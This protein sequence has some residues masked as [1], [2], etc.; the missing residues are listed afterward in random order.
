MST[1]FNRLLEI[2]STETREATEDDKSIAFDIGAVVLDF[3]KKFEG[4]CIED[5]SDIFELCERIDEV[6]LRVAPNLRATVMRIRNKIKAALI[7][8]VFKE[9]Y[10]KCGF[11]MKASAETT[12]KLNVAEIASRIIPKLAV[13]ECDEFDQ[14]MIHYH[15]ED[16]YYALYRLLI[17]QDTNIVDWDQFQE[18]LPPVLRNKF[19]PKPIV[20]GDYALS[21]ADIEPYE[22]IARKLGP[23]AVAELLIASG[24]IRKRNFKK[25][26]N[27]ISK[28]LG[29]CKKREPMDPDDLGKKG[30]IPE[31]LLHKKGVYKTI[32][33][34][35]RNYIYTQLLG[36][37]TDI[38]TSVARIRLE[39]EKNSIER[40][41]SEILDDEDF[42]IHAKLLKE[43]IEYFDDVMAIKVPSNM[44]DKLPNNN[45]GED[46]EFPSLRQ[47]IAMKEMKKKRRQLI[48]FFMG[49]GK[50]AA[51]FLS[52]EYV[53][54]KR[55][56]YI[57]PPGELEKEIAQRVKKYYKPGEEPSVGI[58]KTFKPSKEQLGKIRIN[59]RRRKALKGLTKAEYKK[60][61]KEMFKEEIQKLK[62]ESFKD[63]ISKDVVILPYSM[64]SSKVGGKKVTDLIMEEDFDFMTVDE[65]HHARKTDAKR[66]TRIVYKFATGIK[67]LYDEG[68]IALLS[69]D[70]MPNSP[71]DIV[72]QLRIWRKELYKDVT[73]LR[74]AAKNHLHP[75]FIRN[76]ISQFLLLIDDEEKWE[77]H[78]IPVDF[79]LSDEET[80]LYNSIRWDE[81]IPPMVKMQ[82]LYLCVLNPSLFTPSKKVESSLFKHCTELT[83]KSFD[84]GHN[85]VVVV[86]N[87]YIQ[88]IT[89]EHGNRGGDSIYDKL[90]SKYGEDVQIEFLDGKVKNK[91]E[92]MDMMKTKSDKKRIF[93]VNGSMIREGINLS[94]ISRCIM[95]DPTFN[96]A[97]TV[98]LLK[99]FAREG[100][101]D[102]K[103]YSLCAIGTIMEAIRKH[104]EAKY[105]RTQIVKYGGTLTDDDYALL[106]EEIFTDDLKIDDEFVMIGSYMNDHSL[107][108]R[109][110]MAIIMS[111]LF[112]DRKS[113]EVED[114]LV[115]KI[116]KFIAESY[117]IDWESSPSGNNARMV[118]G[119]IKELEDAG[120]ITGGKFLDVACGPL[121]LRNTLGEIDDGKKR[122]IQSLDINSYMI[123]IGKTVLKD[124]DEKAKPKVKIGKMND[125]SAYPDGSFDVLNNSLAFDY[126]NL[127]SKIT[128]NFG[129][130]QR[131]Q[132]LMEYNRVLKDGG[133]ALITL[134]PNVMP[135]S[136]FLEALKMH[137][138][139]EILEKYTG[140]GVSTDKKNVD[141]FKNNTIVLKKVGAPNINEIKLSDLEL[142][143]A[144]FV[145]G[146]QIRDMKEEKP[147]E[148]PLKCA[149]NEFAIKKFGFE[150]PSE[151]EA[152]Q[153]EETEEPKVVAEFPRTEAEKAADAA[154]EEV[155]TTRNGRIRH[156]IGKVQARFHGEFPVREL[157]RLEEDLG[158]EFTHRTSSKVPEYFRYTEISNPNEYVF[159]RV[160]E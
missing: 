104:A 93:L 67:G 1:K 32:F 30:G 14:T 21:K 96:R 133:I 160:E 105:I 47:R 92:I 37:E 125:L 148:K 91:D 115:E 15:F 45:G 140:M 43:L 116:A 53:G 119:I 24:K 86:E 154:I 132:T 128:V 158:I 60:V 131:V 142:S 41:L 113:E 157:Q 23:E 149:H 9:E 82:L 6:G 103:M 62:E 152:V 59:V 141:T 58:V 44:V 54:A 107:T 109:R 87:K 72:A 127:S 22:H 117:M 19:K 20:E 38:E 2:I 120:I 135:T 100:N 16:E 29:K 65:V 28:A 5:Y 69:A 155:K 56:L 8:N 50:T 102:A 145:G 90:R 126:T 66:N 52:K 27:F 77:E 122:D 39:G 11:D 147:K 4:T 129:A 124:K 118:V 17:D 55:M 85:T 12:R 35:L 31:I 137:F 114:M 106:E 25:A 130:D 97:D 13:I 81:T 46:F 10:E 88:G 144:S 156:E 80:V 94:N 159:Y 49:K 143:R 75:L 57:C 98:Q 111:Q 26:V 153:A 73:T 3:K 146:A 108:D 138:G 151:E 121:V 71:D 63:A 123:D 68:H 36:G 150:Y 18:L 95:L 70:P 112:V 40:I 84:E 89:R 7:Q 61:Y 34:R 79:R 134:P 51:A 48:S 64:F 101:E 78:E 136:E 74:S 33:V 76:E 139:F 110:K 42:E 83:D 99:R